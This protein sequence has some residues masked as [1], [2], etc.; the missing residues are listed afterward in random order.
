MSEDSR[1]ITVLLQEWRS[2]DKAAADRLIDLIYRELH[3]MAA[4]EM[5]RERRDHTLQ[6]T[7]LVHEAYLRLCGAQPIQWTDRAHFF[8]IAARQLRRVLV[9]HARR[10]RSQKRGGAF[11][12]VPLLESDGGAWQFDDQLFA[13]DEALTQLHAL[14]ERAARVIELRF[15][16]GL[17]EEDAAKALDI[18]VATLKRD[19]DFGRTWLASRLKSVDAPRS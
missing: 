10:V 5:R 6:P 18:S 4:R 13:L 17:T 2:G 7:A 12:T 3:Q 1:P 14:D 16:A 9:D 11:A 8:A 19:W 15:F